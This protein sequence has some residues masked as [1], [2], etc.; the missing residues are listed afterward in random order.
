MSWSNDLIRIFTLR[1]EEAS[2]LTSR[3]H[4]EPLGLAEKLALRGH[5]LVCRSCRRLRRQLQFLHS[6][7]QRRIADPEGAGPGQD[8]LSPEARAR[9]EKAIMLASTEG[10]ALEEPE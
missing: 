5:I 6:A 10:T 4:D 1:C 2:I 7:M 3:E 9:I 8:A